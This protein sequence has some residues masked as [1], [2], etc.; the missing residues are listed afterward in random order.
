MKIIIIV[1]LFFVIG[2][3]KVIQ[4]NLPSENP[5]LVVNGLITND[6]TLLI[7]PSYVVLSISSQYI[8]KDTT[9]DYETGAKVILT[10]NIG[11][12]DTLPEVE[13]G[14]YDINHNIIIGVVGRG[15][16]IDIY[17]KEGQHYK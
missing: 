2:C 13:N 6:T 3:N 5:R 16:K 14:R 8:F 4:L 7:A 1:F 15:Y 12:I 10:D 9:P 17:T 11:N